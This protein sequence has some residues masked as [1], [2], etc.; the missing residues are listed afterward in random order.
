MT[1]LGLM[2]VELSPVRTASPYLW[3]L[4]KIY[5]SL[6]TRLLPFIKIEPHLEGYL[7]LTDANIFLS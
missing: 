3:A 5:V 1:L 2:A 4:S 6:R 7:H